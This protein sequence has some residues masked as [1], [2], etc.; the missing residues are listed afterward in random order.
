MLGSPGRLLSEA[1][2]I[3]AITGGDGPDEYIYRLP[4]YVT[5]FLLAKNIEFEI[6]SKSSSL[7]RTFVS[8]MSSTSHTSAMNVL[9]AQVRSSSFSSTSSSK[10]RSQVERTASGFKLKVPGVLVIGYYTTVLPKFP[11]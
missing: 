2:F 8:E 1:D 10:G 11:L 5:S 7:Y 9:V 3:N 4:E 6:S